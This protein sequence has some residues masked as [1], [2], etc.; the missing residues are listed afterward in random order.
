M[1]KLVLLLLVS[2]CLGSLGGCVHY[3]QFRDDARKKGAPSQAQARGICD[4][5]PNADPAH[6]SVWCPEG[7][8]K[9]YL[10]FIEVDEFG[11]MFN[12]NQMNHALGLIDYAKRHSETKF[13][14]A[15][16]TIVPTHNAIV[17][18]FIHGWK[19][20]ASDSSGNVWGFRDAL[21]EL[22]GSVEKKFEDRQKDG[23]T[24]EGEE[25][26]PVVGIYIGW[27]GA[28]TNLGV[29]KEFTFFDR[30]NAAARI[31]GADL[32]EMLTEIAHW[33][34]ECI[35]GAGQNE[36]PNRV[37]K[38]E[39]GV[40]SSENNANANGNSP[41]PESTP[42]PGTGSL[43]VIVGHSF[44]GLVL[45]RTL[46][47]AVTTELLREEAERKDRHVRHEEMP[48]GNQVKPVTD[49]I[50]LVNEA[51]PATESK[52]LLDLLRHHKIQLCAG[53]VH[54]VTHH[55]V[56]K[57]PLFLSITST[58]DWATGLTLPI[59]QGA[60]SLFR[61]NFRTY[62]DPEPKELPHQ[63]TY[64][65]HSS[66]HLP[67]LFSHVLGPAD[68]PKTLQWFEAANKPA[69]E[70]KAPSMQPERKDENAPC[71]QLDIRNPDIHCFHST[72]LKKDYMIVPLSDMYNDTPYWIMQM[73][74]EFVP[75]HS[76]IFR[77]AFRE[78]LQ[79]FILQRLDVSQPGAAKR[80]YINIQ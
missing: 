45:E 69:Q 59:G 26:E 8:S 39:A 43:S 11:E 47:Q 75:D 17:V 40:V 27:R 49:L 58:G 55:C 19:N 54:P 77:P 60:S 66:A 20:N 61:K 71:K 1:K 14:K 62:E 70:E 42:D 29:V 12:R 80:T 67:P 28:V 72:V 23:N 68:D 65:L 63:K 50:V 48:G 51:A 64:Y 52:Q 25:P 41:V 56:E 18:T 53:E 38:P 16:G 36:C 31:P 57:Q 2:L 32:T 30:R 6:K 46:T 7:K 24:L 13:R 33:T 15:D 21:N 10:A 74:P 3:G 22:A 76:Q 73:G 37:A 5:D 44:G 35:S 4:D 79:Q 34:K 78:L 9:Y